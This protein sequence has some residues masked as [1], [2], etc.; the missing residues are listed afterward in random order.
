MSWFEKLLPSR[1]RTDASTKKSIPEGLWTKCGGCGAVL[2][3]AEL[4]R[5]MDVCPK[6]NHHHRIGARR[7]LELFL[8]KDGRQEIGGELE[9]IDILKFKDSKNIKIVSLRLKRALTRKMR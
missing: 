6:C 2:Y 5:V 9:P 8:D 3:R 7:R 1:I 4:E